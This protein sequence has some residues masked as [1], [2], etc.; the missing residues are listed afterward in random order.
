MN[1]FIKIPSL[2]GSESQSRLIG[3]LFGVVGLCFT[4]SALAD[5]AIEESAIDQNSVAFEIMSEVGEH[6]EMINDIDLSAV[7]GMGAEATK[8]ESGDSFA[9]LLWDERGNGNKRISGHEIDGSQSYQAVNLTVN[10]R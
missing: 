7:M 9:V 2:N 1:R 6:A 10:H 4:C 8:L 5:S 3:F